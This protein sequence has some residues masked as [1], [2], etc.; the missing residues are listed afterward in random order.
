VVGVVVLKNEQLKRGTHSRNT[1]QIV[2][3][4]KNS[5]H[6]SMDNDSLLPRRLR[7]LYPSNKKT[8]NLTAAKIKFSSR[9][10]IESNEAT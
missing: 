6:R 3:E 10:V 5:P 4:S 1:N 9:E 2:F 8:P 7:Q